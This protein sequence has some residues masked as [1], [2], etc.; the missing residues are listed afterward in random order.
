MG[1]RLAA[2]VLVAV[3][4]AY[5]AW[6]ILGLLLFLIGGVLGWRWVR[7][8]WVRGTH[9]LMI[10]IVVVQ[11]W[12]G[13]MCP[14]TIWE[15]DL[16]AKAGEATYTGSFIG[17]WLHELL[18]FEAEPWVFTLCYSVFGGLVLLTLIFVPVRWRPRKSDPGVVNPGSGV[19][20]PGPPN[21]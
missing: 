10:A 9:L 16:R 20:D 18:F 21:A 1:Y 19:T 8:R 3:H 4:V 12:L 6:V 11:A 2:D 7:N 13:V 14:L 15:Q 17:H 5:V